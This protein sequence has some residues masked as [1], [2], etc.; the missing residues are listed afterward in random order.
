MIF[1]KE[2]IITKEN[3]VES[4]THKNPRLKSVEKILS[5]LNYNSPNSF[6]ISQLNS[7]IKLHPY[8][9][10]RC[11]SFLEGMGKVEIQTNGRII[12]VRVRND[13]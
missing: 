3:N 8:T 2:K 5:F 11:I 9:I 1:N 4:H 12:M 7:Q 13:N 10:K 6:T